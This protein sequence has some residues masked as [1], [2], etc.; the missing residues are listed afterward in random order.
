MQGLIWAGR[1]L[2]LIALVLIALRPI[3]APSPADVTLAG[4]RT[5][6]E[7]QVSAADERLRADL[8]K[9]KRC[10]QAKCPDF[11][12]EPALAMEPAPGWRVE[13]RLPARLEAL[14]DAPLETDVPP[15]KPGLA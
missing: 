3:A 14:S 6:T 4:L 11:R 8:G 7:R 5:A 12:P 15:P 9:L 10:L 13:T 2:G 1:L